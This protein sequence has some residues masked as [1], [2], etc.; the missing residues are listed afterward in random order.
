MCRFMCAGHSLGGALAVVGTH[1]LENRH[2][3]AACYTFGAPRV[4]GPKW[5][6][7]LKSPVYRT[8]NATDGVPLV[9]PSFLLAPFLMSFK[10]VGFIGFQHP[11]FLTYL[12]RAKQGSDGVWPYNK[13]KNGTAG[14]LSRFN[15]LLIGIPLGLASFNFKV[16]GALGRDHRIS[17][18][19]VKLE[20]IA[21]EHNKTMASPAPASEPPQPDK[22]LWPRA[23]TSTG[24]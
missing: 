16:L 1:R 22:A 3:I 19:V 9:P 14:V 24:G 10:N 6:D 15:R 20:A 7:K 2:H 17:A 11:G 4:G 21:L 18:Y 13:Y 12:P 8:V 5:T 23:V